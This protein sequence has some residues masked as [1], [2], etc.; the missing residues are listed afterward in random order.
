MCSN[1]DKKINEL[2]IRF[3]SLQAAV[4]GNQE[5]L[6][7]YLIDG[8]I[9]THLWGDV[10]LLEYL[11]DLPYQVFCRMLEKNMQQVAIYYMDTFYY[12]TVLLRDFK[13][14]WLAVNIDSTKI[15][16]SLLNPILN[17]NIHECFFYENEN[18]ENL[19]HVASRANAEVLTEILENAPHL[20]SAGELTNKDLPL[21][22]AARAF[23]VTASA[24]LINYGA[25]YRRGNASNINPLK[26]LM[27]L[28][29]NKLLKL[30]LS[31]DPKKRQDLLDALYF[32]VYIDKTD[33]DNKL[34]RLTSVATHIGLRF[35]GV[36]KKE[37]LLRNI[38]ILDELQT[39]LHTY[40]NQPAT[41]IWIILY[42]LGVAGFFV[43]TSIFIRSLMNLD[44]NIATTS[45]SF[46]GMLI[47]MGL[48]VYFIHLSNHPK[49]NTALDFKIQSEV[50][51]HIS[52]LQDK[53]IEVCITKEELQALSRATKKLSDRD[54]AD[55]TIRKVEKVEKHLRNID[56]K[57]KVS[58]LPFTIYG[59][60]SRNEV[61]ITIKDSSA[62]LI[63]GIV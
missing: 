56:S 28:S 33:Q 38:E 63:G 11:G 23:A 14:I 55:K 45:I 41:I 50:I 3:E 6:A 18:K 12:P 43:C 1:R 60:N 4:T 54:S 51:N 49:I 10:T 19:V 17:R 31:I 42:L 44:L 7:R 27:L 39:D 53:N 58:Q 36:A 35:E 21:H 62:P 48:T 9:Q 24:I 57:L 20:I 46:I 32:N 59:E 26:S 37:A 15:F 52:D 13:A 40:K 47:D 2:K 16:K 34:E 29:R 5:R 25:D 8:I 30:F 61:A 22:Y